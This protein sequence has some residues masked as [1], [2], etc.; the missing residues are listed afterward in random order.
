M[1]MWDAQQKELHNLHSLEIVITQNS[2]I[3]SYATVID[4]WQHDELFRDFFIQLLSSLPFDAF[5]WETPPITN[6]TVNQPFECVII[7]SPSLARVPDRQTFSTYFKSEESVITFLNLDKD[8]TLVV[9]CP[10]KI[11]C[12]YSH[13]GAFV[14]H[15]PRTQQHALWNCVGNAMNKRIS[16]KPVW[17]STA[18]GGIAWL[19]IRL[20]NFPKYYH[21]RP[22]RRMH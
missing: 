3:A 18:G 10:T 2:S 12:D 16:N 13:L 11:I 1:I 9:P 22:Y 5:R 14:R 7:D 21:H 15:A 20:D 4:A 8:A 17:L 6:I 19:H